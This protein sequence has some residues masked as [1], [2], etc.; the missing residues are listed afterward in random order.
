MANSLSGMYALAPAA[1]LIGHFDVADFVDA[2]A[3]FRRVTDDKIELPV[4]LQHRSRYRSAHCCLNDGVDVTG[5]EAV[6]GRF[7]AI[8]LDVQIGLPEYRK[9]AEV[10]NAANLAHLVADLL[11]QLASAFRDWDRRS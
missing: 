4:A 5:I 3:V 10:G 8:H 2:V 11:G 9:D 6:A 1:C 7:G